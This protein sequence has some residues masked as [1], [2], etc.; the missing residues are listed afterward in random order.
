MGA[1]LDPEYSPTEQD[2]E[3]MELAISVMEMEFPCLQLCPGVAEN[4]NS[5]MAR[6]VLSK[7]IEY[8]RNS[9]KRKP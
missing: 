6:A 9:D 2:P 7:A 5:W 1:L 4:G 8:K 3:R